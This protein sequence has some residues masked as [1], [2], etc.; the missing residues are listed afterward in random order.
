MSTV[1]DLL[2]R[3][4]MQNERLNSIR[5]EQ[6]NAWNQM[7]RTVLSRRHNDRCPDPSGNSDCGGG[8]R[9]LLGVTE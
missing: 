7:V 3:Q 9:G 1:Q 5:R 4:A 2:D 8:F 6:D